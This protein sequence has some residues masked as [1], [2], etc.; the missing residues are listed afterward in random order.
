MFHVTNYQRNENQNYNQVIT[1]HGSERPS[2]K[3]L[4]TISAG[5][6]VE[7][8]EPPHTVGGDVNWYNHYRE[9][10]EY[11]LKKLKIQLPYD[12]AIPILGIYPEKTLTGK[13][14]CTAMF[15]KHYL[16]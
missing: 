3:S 16:Q 1:S 14:S 5:K 8:R 11:F 13:D 2:S 6:G 10:H 7:K 4:Q 12:P 9:R 15:L